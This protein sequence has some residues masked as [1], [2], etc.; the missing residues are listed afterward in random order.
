[1]FEMESQQEI[2]KRLKK[3]YAETA[4]DDVSVIEGSFTQDT[5]SANAK[6]FEKAYAEMNLIVEAAFPQTSWGKYLTMGA[7][8]FG[9]FRRAA[10]K[11]L[12]VLTVKGTAGTN[13]PKGSL[14][15]TADGKNFLTQD[16]ARLDANGTAQVKAE[17]QE[18]GDKYNVEAGSIVKIPVSIY[19]VSSVT[20]EKAAYDG[21]DEESDSELLE[22]LLFKV[23]QPATSGNP[24]HYRVWAT[25]VEGVGGVKVVRLWNGNGTVKVIITDANNGIASDDL[26]A[27]VQSHLEEEAPIGATITVVSLT[28]VPVS[29]ELKV[30]SGTGNADGIKQAVNRYF[31]QNVFNAE[32]VSY[33][34]IGQIILDNESTTGVA[35]YTALKINGGIENIPLTA[36]ELPTVSEVSLIE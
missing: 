16:A 34:H 27:K 29:I 20:N 13:V 4:G 22:R 31:N 3:Y 10:T 24:Y 18:T 21:F 11:A 14:F 36:E 1:M 7:E 8:M 23:Q 35:D 26:I 5:L 33:A 17:A 6:E 12:A 9:I 2:L 19:G 28:P 15:A 30:T 32:Y 25:E